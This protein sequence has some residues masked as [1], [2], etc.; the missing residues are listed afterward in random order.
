M[1]AAAGGNPLEEQLNHYRTIQKGTLSSPGATTSSSV[2]SPAARR[3]WQTRTLPLCA[4]MA[5]GVRPLSVRASTRLGSSV[6]VF[7]RAS[8]GSACSVLDFLQLG[9]GFS[10]RNVARV[11]SRL[12]VLDLLQL[13][14]ALSLRANSRCGSQCSVHPA[15]N[16][17]IPRRFSP[18][19]LH[20]RATSRSWPTRWRGRSRRAESG[21]RPGP[22]AR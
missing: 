6:S 18:G 20:R 10:M 17:Q 3:A 5:S 12:S 1:A 14:S 16:W 15:A 8:L 9:S 11:G 21:R 4:A 2:V 19:G 22:R 13:G 7:A